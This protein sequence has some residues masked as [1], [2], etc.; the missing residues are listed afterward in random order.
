MVRQCLALVLCTLL[1][2]CALPGRSVVVITTDTFV[3]LPP[4]VTVVR[5]E[6]RTCGHEVPIELLTQV[7]AGTNPISQL[8][9]LHP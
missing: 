9:S 8:M 1:A 3:C 6:Y 2:G 4:T 7:K 5:T